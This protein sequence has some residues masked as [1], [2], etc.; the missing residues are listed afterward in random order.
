MN[1]RVCFLILV[2]GMVSGPLSFAEEAGG[3]GEGGPRRDEGGRMMGDRGNPG[4]RSSGMRSMMSMGGMESMMMMQ[5]MRDKSV[6]PT[7]DGGLIVSVANKLIKYDK[8]L[9]VIKEVEIKIN[10][11]SM[12]PGM[13]MGMGRPS[14]G[15]SGF[16]PAR[17]AP[18]TFTNAPGEGPQTE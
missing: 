6:I 16:R 17:S 10:M 18:E 11:E 4:A 1:I 12:M 2:L 3:L 14:G 8:D 13:P 5:V 9:N 7:S 15:E